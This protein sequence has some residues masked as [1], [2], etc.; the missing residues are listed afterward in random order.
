[1]N[2]L[3][4]L[5]TVSFFPSITS[6]KANKP[7]LRHYKQLF[8]LYSS[9]KFLQKSLGKSSVNQNYIRECWKVKLVARFT[10]GISKI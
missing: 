3:F 4:L 7:F 10:N 1:M 8:A 9:L 5:L 2:K 6:Q